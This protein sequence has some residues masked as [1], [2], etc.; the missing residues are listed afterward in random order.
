[1]IAS[2][3]NLIIFYKDFDSFNEYRYNYIMEQKDYDEIHCPMFPNNN[4]KEFF[5]KRLTSYESLYCDNTYI[6]YLTNKNKKIK[7]QL[8]YPALEKEEF[9]V[10]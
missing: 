5:T 7:V 9:K 4:S 6:E 2:T 3:C 10:N 1:M 8:V